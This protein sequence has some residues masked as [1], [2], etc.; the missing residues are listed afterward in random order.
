MLQNP[1]QP[2]LPNMFSIEPGRGSGQTSLGGEG[3]VRLRPDSEEVRHG[4]L[5]DPIKLHNFVT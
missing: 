4:H 3:Q 1:E 5:N 2:G